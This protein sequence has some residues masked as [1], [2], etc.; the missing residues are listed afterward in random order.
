MWP[1]FLNLEKLLQVGLIGEAQDLQKSGVKLRFWI[2]LSKT[3]LRIGLV[4]LK[5][6]VGLIDHLCLGSGMGFIF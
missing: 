3:L 5:L 1:L 4:G 6:R 2:K